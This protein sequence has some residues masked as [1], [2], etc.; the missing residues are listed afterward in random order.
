MK[1]FHVVTYAGT[2]GAYGGPLSVAMSQVEELRERGH[3]ATVLSCSDD[4]RAL[5]HEHLISFPTQRPY[6]RAGFPVMISSDMVK[7]LR[8]NVRPGDVLHIHAAREFIPVLAVLGI[9]KK[10][11]RIVLQTHGNYIQNDR[12]KARVY[13]KMLTKPMYS[14]ASKVL[15]LQKREM[16]RQTELVASLGISNSEGFIEIL[17]NGVPTTERKSSYPESADR[18]RFLFLGRLHQQ[19]DPSLFVK[20]AALFL[21]S[22]G[23][24]TF[25]LVGPDGGERDSVERLISSAGVAEHVNLEGPLARDQV[26]KRILMSHALVLPS[27]QDTFPMSV[28]EA[29]SVGVPPIVSDCMGFADTITEKGCGLVARRTAEDMASAMRKVQDQ[30]LWGELSKSCRSVIEEKFSVSQVV[31][32][33]VEIYY[34]CDR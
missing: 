21:S 22:G 1:I 34:G 31:D 13:D 25:S 18:F 20:A 29:M 19:K 30:A 24:A 32:R 5:S 15:V 11:C 17:P 7:F 28:L 16:S 4:D 3:D 33:L 26:A 9:G 14:R 2:D 8:T 27:F 6:R 10:N 12:I 23:R